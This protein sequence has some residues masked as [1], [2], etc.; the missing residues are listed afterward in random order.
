[1]RKYGHPNEALFISIQFRAKYFSGSI[2]DTPPKPRVS[3]PEVFLLTYFCDP[4]LYLSLILEN[5][6]WFVSIL[7]SRR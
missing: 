3:L 5:L 7:A 2:R 1:M 4:D 6:V